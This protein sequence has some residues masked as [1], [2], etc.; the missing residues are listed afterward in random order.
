MCCKGRGGFCTCSWI[1]AAALAESCLYT[2]NPLKI[3]KL[4]TTE[5]A[6]NTLL[7]ILLLSI[8]ANAH[9]FWTYGLQEEYGFDDVFWCQFTELS[10]FYSEPFRKYLWPTL[11]FLISTVFPGFIV[12]FSA[13]D[14]VRMRSGC[15][16]CA[17]K[18]DQKHELKPEVDTMPPSCSGASSSNRKFTFYDNAYLLNP[19][20]HDTFVYMCVYLA[21]Y[22][23]L[24]G[25]PETLF[26][27]IIDFLLIER[28]RYRPASDSFQFDSRMR[29]GRTA[30]ALCRDLLLSTKILIYL[31][32]PRFRWEL[33]KILC[34]KAKELP[35]DNDRSF[36]EPLTNENINCELNET[37]S[38]TI[39]VV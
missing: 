34:C 22:C 30:C 12:V 9:F 20:C 29:L 18:A 26:S 19:G 8:I 37:F 24:L 16:A 1:L 38:T 31:L 13:V 27:Y 39:T 32:W 15:C 21:M 11:D 17:G 3:H 14:I 33:K 2:R 5:R 6:K 23:T 35:P 28:M 25:M 10:S 4:A 36:E 7:F